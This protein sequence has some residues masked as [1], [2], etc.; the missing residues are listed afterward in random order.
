MDV[1]TKYSKHSY[2]VVELDVNI[3]NLGYTYPS[4]RTQKL[5]VVTE[6]MPS[7]FT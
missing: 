3:S 5:D 6:L 4:L 1:I 2:L 7:A